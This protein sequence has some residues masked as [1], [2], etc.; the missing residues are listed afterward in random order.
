MKIDEWEQVRKHNCAILKNKICT[1][2]TQGELE[3]GNGIVI[4]CLK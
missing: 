2:Y 4:V 1:V 3:N